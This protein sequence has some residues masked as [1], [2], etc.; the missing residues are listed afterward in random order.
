MKIEGDDGRVGEILLVF[1]FYFIGF[2]ELLISV[3]EKWLF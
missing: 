3:D 2:V 1:M